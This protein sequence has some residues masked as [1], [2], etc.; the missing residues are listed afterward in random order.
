MLRLDETGLIFKDDIKKKQGMEQRNVIY[1][2]LKNALLRE[3]PSQDEY[4]L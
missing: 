4:K 2:Y 1:S 3:V